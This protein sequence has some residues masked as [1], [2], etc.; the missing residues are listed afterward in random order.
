L[1]GASWIEGF[2]ENGLAGVAQSLAM[3]LPWYYILGCLLLR[4]RKR[5]YLRSTIAWHFSGTRAAAAAMLTEPEYRYDMC[6]AA[7]GTLIQHLCTVRCQPWELDH[8]G[9]KYPNTFSFHSYAFCF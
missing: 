7:H 4:E 6:S 5:C 3:F 8:T 9:I 1:S 2:R